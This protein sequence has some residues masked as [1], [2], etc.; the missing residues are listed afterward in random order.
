MYKEVGYWRTK[1][2]YLGPFVI[3][4]PA[5]APNLDG[6]AEALE[7]SIEADIEPL[8]RFCTAPKLRA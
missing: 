4:T 6:F 1:Y 5:E 3:L 2:R 8:L 7:G